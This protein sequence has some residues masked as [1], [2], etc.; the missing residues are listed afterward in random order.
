MQDQLSHSFVIEGVEPSML[1][2]YPICKAIEN[3]EAQGES[4]VSLRL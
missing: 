4:V 3:N 2:S 1:F